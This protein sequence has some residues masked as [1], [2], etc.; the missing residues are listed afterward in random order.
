MEDEN[1]VPFVFGNI[2]TKDPYI[3]INESKEILNALQ[4][5]MIEFG[6]IRIDL[7]INPY[8]FPPQ[9]AEL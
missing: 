7:Y 4:D 5:I 9:I 3:D 6:I 1:E 8:N 2:V